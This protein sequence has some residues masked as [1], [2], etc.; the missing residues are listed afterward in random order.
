MNIHEL[1]VS[2][3]RLP[4]LIG[5]D[6]EGVYIVKDLAVMPHVMVC[7]A[8]GTGK[9]AFLQTALALIA[10]KNTMNEVRLIICAS[11]ASDYKVFEKIPHLYAPIIY[12]TNKSKVAINWALVEIMN[13]YKLFANAGVSDLQAYNRSGKGYLP[14]IVLIVD[15]LF[16]LLSK[17]ESIDVIQNVLAK[18]RQAGVHCILVTSTPTNTRLKKDLVPHIP[19]KVCFAVASVAESKAILGQPIAAK[20]DYPGHLVFKG[21]NSICVVEAVYFQE[22]ELDYGLKESLNHPEY[23]P[24]SF[25]PNLVRL[26]KGFNPDTTQH[27]ETDNVNDEYSELDELFN[28]A[29]KAVLESKQAS[30]SMLQRQMKIGYSRAARIVD[31]MEE[32]GIVG[33]F[34]GSKPREVLLTREQWEAMTSDNGAGSH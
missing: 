14:R 8:S 26:L 15:D 5:Q 13:R 24:V 4:F 19:S 22:E 7:G 31:Q 25:D 27:W 21:I 18:G 34:E 30:V 20:L 12:D 33:P 1:N 23:Q 10:A 3:G 32:Q 28:Q 9:T 6:Q 11:K 2:I 17:G 16:D 29:V